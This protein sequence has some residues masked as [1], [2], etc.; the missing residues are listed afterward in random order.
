M[1]YILCDKHYHTERSKYTGNQQLQQ[2]VLVTAEFYQNIK[3]ELT[4]VPSILFHS[5]KEGC[6][7]SHSMSCCYPDTKN[8]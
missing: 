4:A 3:E 2:L 6:Y 8:T 1:H 5:H 7:Q